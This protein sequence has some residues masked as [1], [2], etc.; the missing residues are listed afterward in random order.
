MVVVALVSLLGIPDAVVQRI[1]IH[2]DMS[3]MRQPFS[4]SNLFKKIAKSL[5]N[6][7]SEATIVIA[8]LNDNE[9]TYEVVSCLWRNLVQNINVLKSYDQFH[10]LMDN[11]DALIEYVRLI[12]NTCYAFNAY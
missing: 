11:L 2:T 1:N 6:S 3:K 4:T 10:L 9:Q 12:L 8:S 5:V 7:T